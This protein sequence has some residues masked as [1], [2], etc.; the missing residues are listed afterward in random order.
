MNGLI[1]SSFLNIR[2]L[3]N[4]IKKTLYVACKS[5]TFEQNSDILWIKFKSMITPLLDQMQ[6]SNGISGYKITKKKSMQKAT[7]TAVIRIY[8]IEA[9]E[10]FEITLELAD[11][12]TNVIDNL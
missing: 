6:T 5:I 1:A 7:L 4:D 11:E 10:N 8:P 9:V 2:Q 3:C 12:G